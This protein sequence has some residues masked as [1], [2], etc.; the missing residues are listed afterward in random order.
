MSG[1]STCRSCGRPIVWT[2]TP[3]DKNSPVDPNPRD[4]GNLVM[5]TA[6]V[7]NGRP[8]FTQAMYDPEIHAGMKRYVSHFVTCP[9][10]KNFRRRK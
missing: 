9:D 5:I 1:S 3:A 2:K 10:A 4:D 7:E 6:G 8:L